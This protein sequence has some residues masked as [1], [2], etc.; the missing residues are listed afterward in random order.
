MKKLITLLAAVGI[1]AASF[2]ALEFS[3]ATAIP[4]ITSAATVNSGATNTTTLALGGLK[5]NPEVFVTAN[6]NASRTALN[7]SL[8]ATNSIEGGWTLYAAQSITATNAGVYRLQFP[9]EY[10]PRDAQVRIGSI[11]AATAVTAFILSY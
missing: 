7:L 6:G 1:A 2:A 9:G 3:G 5:G 10:L 8:W 4:V 11:G